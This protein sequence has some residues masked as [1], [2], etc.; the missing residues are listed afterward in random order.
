MG[1][2]GTAI[3]MGAVL[4]GVLGGCGQGT[5]AAPGSTAAGPSAAP[6]GRRS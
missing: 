5:A 4:I 2:V 1:R 3:A 6:G